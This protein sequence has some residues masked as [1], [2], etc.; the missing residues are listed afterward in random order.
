MARELI[1]K[2]KAAAIISGLKDA[3]DVKTIAAENGMRN[4]TI[5]LLSFSARRIAGLGDE[6]ALLAAVLSAPMNEVSKPVAGNN[7]VYVFTVFSDVNGTASFDETTEKLA[8]TA[9]DSYRVMYQ[10][11]QAVRDA[12]DVEDSRIRFY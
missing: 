6:P 9:N 2:Q 8:M 4:D 12:A 7:G 5:D 1:N 11:M 10:A 3:A